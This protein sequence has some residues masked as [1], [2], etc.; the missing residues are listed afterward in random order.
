[1]TNKT[2]QTM[3]FALPALLI[4]VPVA[5]GEPTRFAIEQDQVMV[6][7]QASLGPHKQLVGTARAL[8][9]SVE[10]AQTGAA[11]KL[12]LPVASLETGSSLADAALKS[13]LHSEQFPTIDLEASSPSAKGDSAS[14]TFTGTLHIAGASVLVSVPAKLLRDGRLAFVH[15]EFP[16]SLSAFGITGTSIAGVAVGDKVEVVVDARLHTLP[17]GTA[18][19][20]F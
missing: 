16:I 3:L 15:A 4:G 14:V 5:A 11:V 6:A 10:V 19:A 17:E 8:S 18:V 12:Q 2:L 7:F 13:A 9:G 20:S 1:M